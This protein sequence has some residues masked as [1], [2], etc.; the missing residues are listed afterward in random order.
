MFGDSSRVVHKL[1]MLRGMRKESG[2]RVCDLELGEL[3]SLFPVP[4]HISHH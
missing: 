4:N 1:I 3:N 2:A